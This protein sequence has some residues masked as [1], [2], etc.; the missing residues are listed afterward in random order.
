MKQKSEKSYVLKGF[1]ITNIYNNVDFES[2]DL[3]DK[4]NAKSELAI[5]T[6][7]KII[8]FGANNPQLEK[9]GKFFYEL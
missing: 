3:I 5:N 1:D 7:K 8:L 6:N 4:Q 2:F 9:D